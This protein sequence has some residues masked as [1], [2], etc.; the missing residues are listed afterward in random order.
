METEYIKCD[1]CG[2]NDTVLFFT[3]NNYNVVRCRNCGLVYV[4]PRPKIKDLENWY[5]NTTEEYSGYINYYEQRQTHHI[6]KA[7]RLLNEIKY[8]KNAPGR[9][10]E[11]GCGGGFFLDSAKTLGWECTGIDPTEKFVNYARQ[12][13]GLDNVVKGVFEL[14]YFPDNYFDVIVMFDV[15][16]HIFS[17]TAVLTKVNKIL[18]EDGLFVFSTG[19]G[20]D[21]NKKEDLK[22]W[23]EQW[24]TPD[25]LYHLSEQ[26]I[27]KYLDK[28]NFNMLKLKKFD[29]LERIFLP[30]SLI[31]KSDSI[32][33]NLIKTILI[34]SSVLV[35]LAKFLLQRYYY[36][37]LNRTPHYSLVT[38]A[39]RKI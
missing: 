16:S 13:L 2:K 21:F 14:Y 4:N 26:L 27:Y 6:F 23:G 1:L 38:Y 22:I 10:L 18:K 32:L 15:L 35:N 30:E 29:T 37:L 8:F 31:Q 3:E 36:S 39:T 5:S 34:K 20:A 28:T 9:L 17:P 7:N 24:S 33:K 11:I 19:N 12:Q 25:H